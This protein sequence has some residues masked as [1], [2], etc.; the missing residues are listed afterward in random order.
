MDNQKLTALFNTAKTKVVKHGPVILTAMG[1]VGWGTTVVLAVKETPK[2]L[3]L[4]EDAEYDKGEPLTVTEKVKAAYKPYIPAAV[5]AV[6]STACLI[7]ACKVSAGRTAALA[8]A[9]QL[10]A[11]ALKDYTEQ[12]VETVGEKK[13]K[14][15][16][17]KVAEK[18]LKENPVTTS[19]IIHT[20]RGKTRCYD[21]S[22]GRYFDSSKILIEQACVQL[23]KRMQ[24][25][26][27]YISLNEYYDEIG[28]PHIPIGD[29]VGWNAD[30]CIE[31]HFSSL[32]D[33]EGVPC[34]V[35]DYLVAPT[36]DF[37][38]LM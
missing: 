19:Q 15:I 17:D 9:Y 35:I 4:I 20:G 36:W 32:V 34:L 30:V 14:V 7:G 21:V 16:R 3:R 5:T 28:L 31:P 25:G 38:N 10:S 11:T 18:K 8:T 26:E 29:K 23:T 1:I 13:E 2:A 6:T 24:G 12:V 33:D 27:M 22:S 37:T